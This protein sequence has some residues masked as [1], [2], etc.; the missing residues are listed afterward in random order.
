MGKLKER[1]RAVFDLVPPS[2]VADIGTDH[3][4]L[5]R[6]LFLGRKSN[7]VIAT[8]KNAGPCEAARRTLQDAGIGDQVEV[9]C[10]DGLTPL[11]VGEVETVVIAGMGGALIREILA[12]SPKIAVS[13]TALVLQPQNGGELLRRYLYEIGWHIDDEALAAE[14]GLL[15][16]IILA[17]PGAETMPSSLLLTLG[18]VLCKKKPPLFRERA[19]ELLQKCKRIQVG[20]ARS[21][22]ENT[23]DEYERI[24]L[25]IKELEAL[26]DGEMPENHGN[27]GGDCASGLG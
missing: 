20:M 1:L 14:G 2:S 10:G 16:E 13:L 21:N 9:R 22:R 23:G 17:R 24:I 11:A 4:Y 3:G 25:R 15:Y 18:P 19:N 8:D 12:A 6:E 7:F 26:V 5:A 27:H